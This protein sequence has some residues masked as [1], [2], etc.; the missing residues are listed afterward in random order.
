M[1]AA[2]LRQLYGPTDSELIDNVQRAAQ[3]L[4]IATRSWSTVEPCR[5]AVDEALSTAHGL[6]RCLAQLQGLKRPTTKL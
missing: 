1:T 6:Q 2:L 4:S 5:A 3:R